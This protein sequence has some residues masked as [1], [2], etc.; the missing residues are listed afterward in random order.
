MLLKTP[1]VDAPM[2]PQFIYHEEC[3]RPPFIPPERANSSCHQDRITHTHA[4][5]SL[6]AHVLLRAREKPPPTAT[7]RLGQSQGALGMWEPP[8]KSSLGLSHPP[9]QTLLFPMKRSAAPCTARAA[10]AASAWPV[11]ET[12]P[13]VVS[14]PIYRSTPERCMS[15]G[16]A[17]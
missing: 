15:F 5:A 10:P 11:K 8:N 17:P 16:G 1:E 7:L 13:P 2:L 12:K 6:P 9:E 3:N 14:Y 4:E